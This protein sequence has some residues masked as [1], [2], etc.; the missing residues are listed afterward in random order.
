MG[1]REHRVSRESAG[2][3]RRE[4]TYP[5]NRS[6]PRVSSDDRY[7]RMSSSSTSSVHHSRPTST[8]DPI[9]P[10][11]PRLTPLPEIDE[12]ALKLGRI[13]QERRKIEERG[14]QISN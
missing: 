11:S 6:Y 4:S 5:Y 1:Q 7:R 2:R 8:S 3:A 13:R 9:I 14:M 10:D 12:L